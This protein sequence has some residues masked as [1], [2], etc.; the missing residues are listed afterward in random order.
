MAKDI[1]DRQKKFVDEYLI[2]LNATQAAIRAGYS[3]KTARSMGQRLLT[4][5]DVQAKIEKRKKRMVEKV[6]ITQER[7]LSELA[8]IAFSNGSQIAKIVTINAKDAAGNPVTYQTVNFVPT[9]ELPEDTK[10]AISAIKSNKRGIE[11]KMHDKTRALERLG[12]Y[13][14]MWGSNKPTGG[15]DEDEETGVVEL[16][17]VLPEVIPDE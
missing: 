8:A 14:N 12:E 16:P 13:L 5:V 15:D 7:V 11:V 10:R 4:K 9:D 3:A 1:N 2:D 6:E 17:P